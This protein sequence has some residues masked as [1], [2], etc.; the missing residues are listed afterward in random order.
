MPDRPQVDASPRSVTGKH[1]ARLRR[2]GKLPAVVY[3]AGE[4]STSIQIDEHEFDLLRRHV[5][6]NALLDLRVDGGRA[7]PVLIHQLHE[8]P[9]KRSVLHVDFLVVKMTEEM[10]VD[11]PVVFVGEATASTKLGGTLLHLIESVKVRALPD[12]LPQTLELDVT[13][14]VDF[15]TV[16]HVRDLAMPEGATLV[17]DGEEP[18]VRVQAPRIEEEPVAAELPEG[19][20]AEAAEGEAAEGAAAGESEA[21]AGS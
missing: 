17:T 9:V 5:G 11:V 13:P 21:E 2:E 6:R 10:T 1:V 18:L 4:T 20:E 7:K 16:L 19:A 15:D 14:L 12:H 8:H 3:G